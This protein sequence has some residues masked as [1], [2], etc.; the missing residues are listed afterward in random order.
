MF[1]LIGKVLNG[2]KTK[3]GGGGA[4]LLGILGIIRLI[5]PDLTQLPDIG[6]E[7]SLLSL[8]GGFT[9]LG[10]GGK[11]QKQTATIKGQQGSASILIVSGIVAAFMS[12]AVL[13]TAALPGC[14]V[15]QIN[16]QT[17]EAT[18]QT[19]Q[20]VYKGLS[21]SKVTIEGLGE[22]A[23]LAHSSGLISDADY[24]AFSDLYIKAQKAQH[25][26][27]VAIQGLY[28]AI[29]DWY[30][31]PTLQAAMTQASRTAM[32]LINLAAQLGIK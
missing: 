1:S 5:F 3:I 24:N 32:D 22:L 11:L 10:I 21:Y 17:Q 14:S 26:A 19:L 28:G 2:Y 9:A 16:Q 27:I 25:N 13:F 4:I 20:A 30:N 23:N 18:D 8:S 6:L 29:S 7:G 31:V 12:L 15:P